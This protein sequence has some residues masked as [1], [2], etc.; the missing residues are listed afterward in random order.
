MQL[1]AHPSA[2]RLRLLASHHGIPSHPSP[3]TMTL[4]CKI[5]Q[6]AGGKQLQEMI[7]KCEAA[8]QWSVVNGLAIYSGRIFVPTTS[9]LWSAILVTTHETGHEGI[10]KIL[11]CL[12]TS[13]YNAGS[14][15]LMKDYVKSCAMCQCNKSE[16]LHSAGLL[17]HVELPSSI[18]TDIT[19]DYVEGFPQV[20]GKPMV[21]MVVDRFSKYT[22]F[23]PLEGHLYTAVFITHAVMWGTKYQ[24]QP[25]KQEHAQAAA[26]NNPE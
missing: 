2:H 6:L 17:Q 4:Q 13:F 15:K 11:H 1:A 7:K 3:S 22:H 14:A 8:T 5:T 10:Q 20:C 23:I 25:R 16:H 12:H 24:R 18:W 21:L 26:T 19:I 9:S